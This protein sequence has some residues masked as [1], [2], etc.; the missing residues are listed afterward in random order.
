MP[1]SF[2]FIQNFG[3][4]GVYY[5]LLSYLIPAPGYLSRVRDTGSHLDFIGQSNF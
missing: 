4:H 2:G 1:D 5:T 3:L